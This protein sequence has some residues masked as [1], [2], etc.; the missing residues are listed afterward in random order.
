MNE[1]RNVW[2]LDGLTGGLIAT[3]LLLSILAFLSVKAMSAQHNHATDYYKIKDEKNI[4]RISTDNYKH[5]V[6]VNVK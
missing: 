2:A 1:T 4:K 6:T 3:A 5:I